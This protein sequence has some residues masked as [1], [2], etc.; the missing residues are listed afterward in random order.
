MSS[1]K[2]NQIIPLSKWEEHF[3]YPTVSQL[4][5]YNFQNTS[6]FNRCVVRLGGR[7]Y[8]DTTRFWEWVES[9]YE[10]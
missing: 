5:W 10:K 6:D 9:N 3:D 2:S 1:A 8:I 4:R 7:L